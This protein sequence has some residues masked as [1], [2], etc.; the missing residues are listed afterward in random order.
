M[1]SAVILFYNINIS[2]LI[3]LFPAHY[4]ML[5]RLDT[6]DTLRKLPLLF[7]APDKC[8]GRGGDYAPS[9]S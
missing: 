3:L 1:S 4:K 2:N 8:S 6:D 7:P 9:F 5:R